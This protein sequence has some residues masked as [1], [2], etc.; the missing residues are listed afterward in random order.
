MDKQKFCHKAY[1]TRFA[2]KKSHSF[3]Y[4][5]KRY[6]TLENVTKLTVVRER[7]EMKNARTLAD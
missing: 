5:D 3:D 7:I 1:Q 2:I 6:K 4:Y